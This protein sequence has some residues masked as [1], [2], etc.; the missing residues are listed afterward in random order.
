MKKYP[1]LLS[2][3]FL[4]SITAYGQS[5]KFNDLVYYTN[6][7]NGEVFTTLMEGNKFK[8]DFTTEVNGQEWEYFKSITGKKTDVYAK[9]DTEKITVG[10]YTKLY[11]GTL[12]RTVNYTSTNPQNI[13]NMISQAHKYGLTKKFQGADRSNNIY[14]FENDYYEVSIYLRRD[15][16]SGLVEIKQKEFLGGDY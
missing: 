6:L 8:Q 12:L 1:F 2:A 13:I 5:I 10:R 3:L 4:W 15:E 9:P 11:N 16:S 14:L 7:T